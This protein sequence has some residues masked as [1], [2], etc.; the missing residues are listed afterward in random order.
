MHPLTLVVRVVDL[1][2]L[3]VTLRGREGGK[4]RRKEGKRKKGGREERKVEE[5]KGWK[6]GKRGG[7][8]EGREDEE[9]GQE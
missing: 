9:S 8:G 5:R 1:A 2:R 7:K 3:P 4:G 6:E